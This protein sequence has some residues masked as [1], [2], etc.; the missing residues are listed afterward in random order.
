M[1]AGIVVQPQSKHLVTF[2]DSQTLKSADPYMQLSLNGR[3]L[4]YSTGGDLWLIATEKGSSPRKLGKGTIP[5]WS[6]D[7]KRLAYYS[8]ES[9]TLQLWVRDMQSGRTEQLTY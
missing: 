6:P 7:S 9:G 8:T 3:E 5:V 4:M 2:E 1:I